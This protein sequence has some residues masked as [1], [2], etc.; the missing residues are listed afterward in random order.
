MSIQ[1][2]PLNEI[3]QQAINVLSKEIGIANTIRFLNQFSS[4]YGNYT[5]ERM[6]LF[7]DLTLEEIFERVQK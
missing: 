6:E 4:G 3:T 1:T 7:K 5:K 2:Q